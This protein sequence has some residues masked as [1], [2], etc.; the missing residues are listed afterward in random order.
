[1]F[2]HLIT[3]MESNKKVSPIFNQFFLKGKE[4][5]FHLFSYHNLIVI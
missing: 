4:L 2:D 3:E 1:M 5:I